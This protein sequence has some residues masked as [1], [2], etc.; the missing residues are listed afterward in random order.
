MA[1][2]TKKEERAKMTLSNPQFPADRADTDIFFAS[3]ECSLGS[4]LVA[5]NKQ[6]VCAILVG[7]DRA[8]LVRELQGQFPKAKL[9]GGQSGYE[10]IL[11]KIVGL[12][13]HPGISLDL[14]LDVRGTAFQQRVWRAL[15]EIPPGSTATYSEIAEKIEMPKA[16]RA[17]AQACASN[18][19]A[20]AIPCHRVIR[21]NGSL[22]G[23][24]WGAE[25]KSA[26]LE[27]EAH[28]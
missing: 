8:S 1:R 21:R 19:L 23:Y 14:P 13:E 27:R 17:V 3:V 16:A 22:S 6:G 4:T 9:T 24:R 15:Q 18:V 11:A 25:R 20:I 26:L 5:Q 7:D 12:I 2:S 28:A 10:D